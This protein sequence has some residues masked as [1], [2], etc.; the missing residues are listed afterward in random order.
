MDSNRPGPHPHRSN[1]S[2]SGTSY[3]DMRGSTFSSAGR[4]IVNHHHV[5]PA[6]YNIYT[7]SV[8]Q[9]HDPMFPRRSPRSPP[10]YPTTSSSY[11]ATPPPQPFSS[12]G[13]VFAGTIIPT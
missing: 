6:P 3:Y 12:E 9:Y 8:Y 1:S 2:P 7:G 11:T 4:D 13:D 10:T 5:G